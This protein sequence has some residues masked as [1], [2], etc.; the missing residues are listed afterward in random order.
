VLERRRRIHTD[1]DHRH[2][3][4][5]GRVVR[6]RLV[7]LRYAPSKLPRSRY[8]FVVSSA[9]AK[10]ATVRNLVKRRLRAIARDART[11]D[12]L[13]IVVYATKATPP[14]TFAA[15]KQDFLEA[16]AQTHPPR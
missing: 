8:G 3:W 12:P 9:I 10:R 2:V 14:A 1:R 5:A 11:A 4:R 6:G 13:D 16:L 7:V 15:L